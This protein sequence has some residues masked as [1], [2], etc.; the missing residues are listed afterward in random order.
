MVSIP[1]KCLSNVYVSL[2]LWLKITNIFGKNKWESGVLKT[3]CPLALALRRGNELR[4]RGL[5]IQLVWVVD[6]KWDQP[7][8]RLNR[9][10]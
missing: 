8:K 2:K 3:F 7:G 6:C 5:Q 10:V 1:A 4:F 9:P